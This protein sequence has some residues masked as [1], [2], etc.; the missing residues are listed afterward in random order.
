ML[1]LRRFKMLI[2]S[3]G[4]EPRRWPDKDRPQAEALL[5]ASPEARRLFEQ[6]LRLDGAIKEASVRQDTSLW[7]PGERDAALAT[8]RAVVAARIAVR[9]SDRRPA[10]WYRV[11]WM[12]QGGRWAHPGFLRWVGMMVGSGV[13]VVAGLWIGWMQ[14]RPPVSADLFTMLQLAPIRGLAW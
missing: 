1:S 14:T 7:R 3:Y 8:L 11:W 12:L 10:R 9:S 13:V 6:A 4:A 5:K 2:D